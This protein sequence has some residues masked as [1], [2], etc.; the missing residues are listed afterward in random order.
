MKQRQSK[1]QRRR[2]SNQ[3]NTES[4][5]PYSKWRHRSKDGDWT[6][7]GGG[8]K[9]TIAYLIANE[10]GRRIVEDMEVGNTADSDHQPIEIQ[11]NLKTDRTEKDKKTWTNWTEA[12]KKRYRGRLEEEEKA[13]SWT[14]LKDKIIRCTVKE[15]RRIKKGRED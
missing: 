3:E 14:E 5:L 7:I 4:R 11:L 15:N 2:R 12:G 6:Y 10:E 1:K 8:G 13:K 9:S